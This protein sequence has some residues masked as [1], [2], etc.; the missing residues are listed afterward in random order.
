MNQAQ[1]EPAGSDCEAAGS[2]I[3]PAAGVRA[4]VGAE[5][6]FYGCVSAGSNKPVASQPSRAEKKG[7]ATP[8]RD[9]F[10]VEYL[11]DFNATRA[12]IR[13]GYSPK[14]AASQG[15]RLL[16]SATVGKAIARA[17]AKHLSKADALVESIMK[18]ATAIAFI[19]PGQLVDNKGALLPIEQMPVDARRGLTRLRVI[20]LFYSK[21]LTRRATWRLSPRRCTNRLPNW[22]RRA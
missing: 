12:A 7:R 2:R 3:R 15:Q 9:R 16:K 17:E 14:T 4:G 10:V 5:S 6:P 22:P 13:A 21:K 18:K 19:D 11:K 1:K 8:M 20:N